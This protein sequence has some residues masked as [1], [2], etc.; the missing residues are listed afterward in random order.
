MPIAVL[1][2]ARDIEA[3]DVGSRYCA[4]TDRMSAITLASIT[5]PQ[6]IHPKISG[7]LHIDLAIYDHETMASAAELFLFFYQKPSFPT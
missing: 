4:S 5:P 6:D 1:G 7:F 3:I 2:L